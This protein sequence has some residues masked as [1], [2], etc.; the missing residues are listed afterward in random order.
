MDEVSTYIL[1]EWTAE[2]KFS[3]VKRDAI[4]DPTEKLKLDEELI[5]RSIIVSWKN[6]GYEA[7]I[8]QC[9]KLFNRIY[10][11]MQYSNR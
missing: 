10:L 7:T 9:G 1:V 6:K 11:R 3:V 5:G 8:I 4:Q 2:K